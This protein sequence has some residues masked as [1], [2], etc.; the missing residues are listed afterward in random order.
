MFKLNPSI[1]KDKAPLFLLAGIG[2]ACLPHL[3]FQPLSV[4]VVCALCLMWRVAFLLQILAPPPKFLQALIAAASSIMILH[5]QNY[6]LGKDAGISLLITALAI[7]QIQQQDGMNFNFSSC[8]VYFVAAAAFLYDHSIITFFSVGHAVVFVSLALFANAS[9][10]KPSR[11][12]TV[13][14]YNTVARL[15]FYAMPLTLLLFFLTPDFK[16]PL[17]HMPDDAYTA[18]TGLSGEMS[19][20]KISS[21]MDSNDVV[22]R[23]KF[24]TMPENVNNFI[25]SLYWR[26][27]VFTYFDGQTW[28]SMSDNTKSAV[29]QEK[30]RADFS[31]KTNV[32]LKTTQRFSPAKIKNNTEYSITLEPQY[33]QWLFTLAAPDEVQPGFYLTAENELMSKTIVSQPLQYTL[34]LNSSNVIGSA[35]PDKYRYLNLPNMYGRKTKALV[36]DLRQELDPDLPFDVQFVAKALDYF[37][38]NPYYYSRTPPLLEYDPVDEF[39]LK[40]RTGFC[41][42]FASA[43]TFMMRA[44]GIPA[45]VV[46]G[47]RGGEYNTVGGYIIVRQSDAHAWSEVWLHGHGWVKVD[48]TAVIPA[49]R[50]ENAGRGSSPYLLAGFMVWDNVSMSKLGEWL[51]NL[52]YRWYGFLATVIEARIDHHW[53]QWLMLSEQYLLLFLLTLLILLLV[54]RLI[55]RDVNS[56]DPVLQAYEN[57]CAKLSRLGLRRL[58]HESASIFAL[59]VCEARP[60]LEEGVKAIASLYNRLRYGKH[61]DQAAYRRFCREIADFRP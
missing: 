6:N 57:F 38:D 19:P 24:K 15:L 14:S 1:L 25:E 56:R 22:F 34:K 51:D 42:H 36:Q 31:G 21:L 3:G 17:W 26:G 28:Q 7:K 43:F 30:L 47:Y 2:F 60:D 37:R 12:N 10:D 29:L 58:P 49:Y 35:A 23:V 11:K 8:L 41:E 46:T 27:P 16:G 20:G 18:R 40:T 5:G 33:N 9:S 55:H 39:M 54:C 45:R 50:V 4:I 32:H 44:A 53:F 13:S 48:P 52:S 59:R 61:T